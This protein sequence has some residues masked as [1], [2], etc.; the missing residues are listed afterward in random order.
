MEILYIGIGIIIGVAIGWLL[1]ANKRK[2][3]VASIQSQLQESE[4]KK[5][6][7]TASADKARSI[8]EDRYEQLIKDYGIIDSD[9]KT[10]R[11]KT[12]ELG[13]RISKAEAEYRNLL[14]KLNTQKAEMEDL[15][16][17]FTTEFE[18][19]AT[20]ILKNQSQEFTQANLKNIGDVLNPLKEKIGEFEKKV[21]EA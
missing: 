3:E 18:N 13:K 19:I 6:T 9:Y 5:V 15:Q 4:M 21:T 16:K 8:A 20:K 7:E 2:T 11:N 1:S 12:E 10:E 17:K 14:D